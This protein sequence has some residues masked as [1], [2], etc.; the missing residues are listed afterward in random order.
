[1]I[2]IYS[3][4]DRIFK[5]FGHYPNTYWIAKSY[6]ERDHSNSFFHSY[7]EALESLS[8][9]Y[10][11]MALFS[12]VEKYYAFPKYRCLISIAWH[13]IRPVPLTMTL[14]KGS[15]YHKIMNTVF[16]KGMM[17]FGFLSRIAR[18]NYGRKDLTCPVTVKGAPLGPFKVLGAYMAYALGV[19]L[20][21]A[22]LILE[23]GWTQVSSILS[24]FN[25]RKLKRNLSLDESEYGSRFANVCQTWGPIPSQPRQQNMFMSELQEL[26]VSP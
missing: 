25:S 14:L 7:E 3:Q 11:K 17:D 12:F 2:H 26:L 6:Y 4:I 20:S 9:P 19:S 18:R 22:L 13:K 24:Y 10:S 1:M 21:L 15:P 16:I 23:V 8:S 5:Q